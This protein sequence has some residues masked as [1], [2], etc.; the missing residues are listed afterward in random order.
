MRTKVR[1]VNVRNFEKIQDK[2]PLFQRFVTCIVDVT[3]LGLTKRPETVISL[4]LIPA[5]VK[6]F[7]NN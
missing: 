4:F 6:P 5:L 2:W 7:K 3:V 1:R